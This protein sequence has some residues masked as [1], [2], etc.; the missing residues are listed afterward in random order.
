MVQQGRP[1]LQPTVFQIRSLLTDDAWR[2]EILAR[3]DPSLGQFWRATF[4]KMDANAVPTVTYAIDRFDTSMSL[5]AFLGNPQSAYDARRA[6]DESRVVFVCPSGTGEG[7]DLI[8][9]LLLFDLF[10]AGLSRQDTPLAARRTL[11]AWAD[12]LT[13]VDG[14]SHGSVAK[15]LEQLRKYEIRFMGM[16]QMAM[17]LGADTRA[18]LMQNQSLLAATGADF[19]E[20]SFVAKRLPGTDPQTLLSL[21]R[22]EYVMSCMDRGKRTTPFRVRGV[23]I[24]EALADYYNPAGLPALN[25]A[26]DT[27]LARR[28]VAETL[29]IQRGLDQAIANY[30]AHR[31][32]ADRPPD[33]Q[34]PAG[35]VVHRLPTPS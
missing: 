3:L 21:D 32:P 8:T 1:D 9:A 18:A 4:P 24:D 17:R 5:Q 15:I 28:T 26:I 34:G 10:R 30:L 35:D 33:T 16:T 22:F 23:P 20:A 27:N 2:Q 13:A 25:A 29:A 12:E 6:M 19:D 11:W 31:S 14:A 7:D